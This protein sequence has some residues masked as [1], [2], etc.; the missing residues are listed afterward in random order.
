[1]QTL[2]I[3]ESSEKTYEFISSRIDIEAE[4]T[5]IVSTT[6]SFN[7]EKQFTPFFDK[8]VNLKRVN[9][10]RRIN[11]FFEAV[12]LK[13]G[14]NGLFIGNVE[15]YWLRKKRILAK[16]PPVINWFVYTIDFFLKRVSPK[17]WGLKKIYF[18]LSRGQN[19]VLSKAETFGRLYSCGFEIV[20]E[21]FFENRLHFV[22]RKIKEPAYDY[23]PTYGPLIRLKRQGKGGKPIKVYKA[24]TMHAYSEYLQEYIYKHNDLQE[25]GKFKN[26]FRIT[27]AGK[28]LRK[29]WLDELPML[30]NWVKRDLKIVGV[31]PLSEHYLS[32]YPEDFRERRKNY[33]P[34]LLPP[35]YADMPKELE[36]IIESE[37]R[38]L[39]AYDKHP[40][41]T[42]W[43]YFWK[44]FDNIVFKR[45]RSK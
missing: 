37:R 32:L 43:K 25:G 36:D 39:D 29:F 7:I 3:Q 14:D 13:L 16:Y 6:T 27:T 28:I 33:R 40:F 41:L 2:I 19:R 23:S 22:A 1:M 42:D 35:F 26:D 44:A 30:I 12:N 45:A 38:Y 11:K 15:T 5:L 24:R 31:R 18:L 9:D 8:I 10:I 20:D 21:D 4:D 34:G 17:V